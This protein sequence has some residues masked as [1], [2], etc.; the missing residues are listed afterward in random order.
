MRNTL[1]ILITITVT[2]ASSLYAIIKVRALEY[3]SASWLNDFGSDLNNNNNNKNSNSNSNDKNSDNSNKDNNRNKNNKKSFTKE[4]EEARRI[5]MESPLND[6]TLNW[7]QTINVRREWEEFSMGAESNDHI[8][9]GMLMLTNF[10]WNHPN[11]TMG[12]EFY[13]SLRSRELV[14]GIINHPWFHPTAWEDINSGRLMLIRNVTYYVFL[15]RETCMEGN[16]PYYGKGHDH[17]RDVVAGRGDC[18]YRDHHFVPE[19]MNSTVMSSPHAY[20]ILFDCC[21]LGPIR[22]FRKDRELYS[23]PKLILVSLSAY[24]DTKDE[25]HQ[26]L[27]LPPPALQ[28]CNLTE[29]QRYQIMTCDAEHHRNY[30]LTYAGQMRTKV[31]KQLRELNNDRDI[32]IQN[33][34]KDPNTNHFQDWALSSLFSA[35]PRGD[36][37][38]SY[39]FTEVMSCGSIPVVYSDFWGYP[40]ATELINWTS[41]AVIIPENSVNQTID[42]LRKISLKDR[43]VRRQR[44]LEIYE[45]YFRTGE[46][47]IQGILDSIEA[48]KLNFHN[49]SQV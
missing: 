26:D 43:C 30:L 8:P 45:K 16:Y 2:I 15:D 35:A 21:G 42:I 41:V 46:A 38:F 40:F 34:K 11:T 25:L 23:G 7:S 5:W 31:R 9:R 20:Y 44:I 17:N 48:R 10:G 33:S 27:G 32:L 14:Q 6:Q 18:C 36:N 3:P 49:F 4:R 28:K 22:E 37:L 12:L 1:K 24:R 19:V 47:I 39:R 29:Q 13:R